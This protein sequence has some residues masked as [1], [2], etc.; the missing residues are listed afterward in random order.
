MEHFEEPGEDI[1]DAILNKELIKELFNKHM[2]AAKCRPGI[3][4]GALTMPCRS[5]ELSHLTSAV[6]Q[7]FM[8]VE[9]L[10]RLATKQLPLIKNVPTLC[11]FPYMYSRDCIIVDNHG[12]DSLVINTDLGDIVVYINAND[13]VEWMASN[14]LTTILK[15]ETKNPNFIQLVNILGDTE[16]NVQNIGV[17]VSS[18][19]E[20]FGA[21][22]SNILGA[23]RQKV[24]DVAATIDSTDEALRTHG[25][26]LDD[27]V[28]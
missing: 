7:G 24:E 23:L 1:L 15:E 5:Q 17:T 2:E 26:R 9:I 13:Q 19:A 8:A 10:N 28:E 6:V 16:G 20:V 25:Y 12:F 3:H 21:K 27:I 22:L 14:E 4:I 11:T 18:F